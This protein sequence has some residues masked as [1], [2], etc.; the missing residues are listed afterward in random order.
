MQNMPGKEGCLWDLECPWESFL[1][2][3]HFILLQLDTVI[4]LGGM[5]PGVLAAQHSKSL[6]CSE[7]HSQDVPQ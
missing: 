1:P 6:I 7:F 3:G 2:V 5:P 4:D